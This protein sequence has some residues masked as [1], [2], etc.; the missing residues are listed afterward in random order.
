MT[1]RRVA[2]LRGLRPRVPL[3]TSLRS[4]LAAP[5]TVDV[6]G[7]GNA[8]IRVRMERAARVR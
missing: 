6:R 7:E 1:R 2:G 5:P 3:A 8:A 4:R